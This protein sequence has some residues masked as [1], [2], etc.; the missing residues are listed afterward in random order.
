MKE[1]IYNDEFFAKLEMMAKELEKECLEKR[2]EE[3]RKEEEQRLKEDCKEEEANEYYR[4]V[5]SKTCLLVD[6]YKNM[7]V[8]SNILFMD[9]PTPL[10]RKK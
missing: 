3:E 8:D 2:L 6:K 9:N 10:E 1:K 7:M 5:L 4:N